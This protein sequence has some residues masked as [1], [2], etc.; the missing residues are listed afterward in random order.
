MAASWQRSIQIANRGTDLSVLER[1]LNWNA[2]SKVSLKHR[3]ANRTFT[4]MS[5]RFDFSSARGWLFVKVLLYKSTLWQWL[6]CCF[7]YQVSNWHFTQ[8]LMSKAK[9]EVCYK[10]LWLCNI[11]VK[12]P[13]QRPMLTKVR[14]GVW[15][16]LT[17]Q[18]NCL[19]MHRWELR[20]CAL[21]NSYYSQ[22]K[23]DFQWRV[24]GHA[25]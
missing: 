16:Y 15:F 2:L 20:K 7:R 1:V 25:R 12:W 11:S 22:L 13:S 14:L 6:S 4:W 5:L 19:V 10:R 21:N 8:C 3:K 18:P 24:L 9:N 17:F 23:F